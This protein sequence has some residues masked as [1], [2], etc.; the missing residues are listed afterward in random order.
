[1]TTLFTGLSTYNRP[2]LAAIQNQV[3]LTNNENP[4]KVM[5][6]SSGNDAGIDG[7]TGAL[8]TPTATAGSTTNGTHL[9]R[10]RYRNSKTQ[11]ISNPSDNLSY[12]VSGGNGSLRFDVTSDYT[13]ST[14]AKVDTIDI[15]MTPVNDSNFWRAASALNTAT[16]IT[17]SISDATLTQGINVSAIYGNLQDGELF[18]NDPPPTGTIIV[19]HKNRAWVGGDSP[20]LISSSLITFAS[21][22]TSVAYTS[23]NAE[24]VGRLINGNGDTASYEISA[25]S[26]TTLTISAVYAGTSGQKSATIYKKHPNRVAYS[27]LNY[28]ESFGPDDFV[29]DV[30]IGK[31]DRLRAIYSRRDALYFLGLYSSDRL[32]FSVNPSPETSNLLPIN[33]NRGCFNQRCVVDADGRLFA[34][35][36]LGIYEIGEVPVHLSNHI[37]P[38][39]AEFVD[40]S[41]DAQFH[42]IFDP[43]DR[44]MA[45]FVVFL[46][47]TVP[48]YAAVVELDTIDSNDG[49]RWQFYQFRQGITS[50]S[51]VASSDGQVRAWVGD[52]NGYTW[53]FSTTNTFDGVYPTNP[54]I[55][56]T[57]AGCTDTVLTVVEDLYLGAQMSGAIAYLP[58]TGDERVILTNDQNT[59]TL[60][61]SLGFSPDPGVAVWLGSFPVEYRS[62]WWPGQGMQT[63][64]KPSYFYLMLYP[65]VVEGK[66]QVYFYK[67]FST[68]PYTWDPDSSYIPWD[69]VSFENGVLTVNISA[70]A[71]QGNADGFVAVNM[72]SD[73]WR[74]MQYRLVSTTPAGTLR[75][76]D[77][78]FRVGKFEEFEDA[79]E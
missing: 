62:K 41:E 18:A 59:I 61:T 12:T 14:D 23:G 25:V 74:V 5:N 70:S 32:A 42:G 71:V 1:M 4:V 56:T 43:I 10:Y 37:D 6:Q 48:K 11:Y 47:D 31:G 78:G 72:P 69:G 21:G 64:K 79:A 9:I 19:S 36:R 34:F 24:W 54:G 63:K 53:A 3:Y 40:Y 75:I 38:A 65:G 17:V 60:E 7:P 16:A 50:S 26:S 73:Q 45:W 55:V 76:L 30:L 35:D 27:R 33:G 39:L 51:V 77:M 57:D 22:A 28:P 49:P 52:E 44:I 67:D 20:Y 66:I 29:R 46:G 58:S 2:T 68:Q 15:E 8:G 13:A